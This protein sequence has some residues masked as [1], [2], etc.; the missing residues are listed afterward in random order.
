M[1]CQ[2]PLHCF[3]KTK[4]CRVVVPEN[5]VSKSNSH[6]GLGL[7]VGMSHPKTCLKCQN[8]HGRPSKY[9]VDPGKNSNF[10]VKKDVWFSIVDIDF[11]NFKNWLVT[12]RVPSRRVEVLAKYPVTAPIQSARMVDSGNQRI[13]VCKRNFIFYSYGNCEIFIWFTLST[14]KEILILTSWPP[15]LGNRQ[16]LIIKMG[17]EFLIQVSLVCTKRITYWAKPFILWC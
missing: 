9:L 13:L 5:S 8:C 15:W 6:T 10:A 12:A 14:T 17:A 16:G 11:F 2:A 7:Y 4:D 1:L 3:S